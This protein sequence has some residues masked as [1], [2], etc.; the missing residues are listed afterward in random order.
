MKKILVADDEV[1]ILN[2]IKQYLDDNYEVLCFDN[3]KGL[4]QEMKNGL[5]NIEMVFLDIDFKSGMSGIDALKMM[6]EKWPDFN[7]IT[8]MSA[9]TYGDGME[10]V[11]N[12]YNIQFLKK[13]FKTE[14]LDEMLH[15]DQ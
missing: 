7:N 9:T 6:K 15:D 5:D 3:I 13:P 14:E 11:I 2:A 10:S 4:L 1:V 8:L 12:T